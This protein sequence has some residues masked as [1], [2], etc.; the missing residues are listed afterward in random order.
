MVKALN[1]FGGKSMSYKDALANFIA[2]KSSTLTP[3]IELQ[4]PEPVPDGSV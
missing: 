2:F 1:H 3:K 4:I